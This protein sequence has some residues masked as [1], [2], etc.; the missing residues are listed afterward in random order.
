[1][2]IPLT[3]KVIETSCTVDVPVIV[4]P[5]VKVPTI[6][7]GFNSNSTIATPPSAVLNAPDTTAVAPELAPVIVVPI[8]SV[9]IAFTPGEH[10]RITALTQLPSDDL[11]I[12]LFGYVISLFSPSIILKKVL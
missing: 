11:I 1:M 7:S 2:T 8:I 3:V 4:S 5:S 9:E 10:L 12:N 6:E